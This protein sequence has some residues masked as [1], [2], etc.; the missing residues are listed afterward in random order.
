MT[1]SSGELYGYE[2]HSAKKQHLS[3]WVSVECMYF[4]CDKWMRIMRIENRREISRDGQ[5]KKRE[6]EGYEEDHG[7]KGSIFMSCG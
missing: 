4:D 3:C 6:H 7:E 5:K 1:V 2:G